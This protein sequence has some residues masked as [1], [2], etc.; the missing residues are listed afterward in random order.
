ML[1]KSTPQPIAIFEPITRMVEIAI[2][3][4]KLS[5]ILKKADD[6]ST[7]PATKTPKN[8][9]IRNEDGRSYPNQIK[10]TTIN[11]EIIKA[12]KPSKLL[13]KNLVLP[14]LLPKSAAQASEITS[15]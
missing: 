7:I 1:M 14:N 11:P 15:T 5:S 3:T 9:L 4:P 6:D 8:A 12:I 13:F 2:G 10:L